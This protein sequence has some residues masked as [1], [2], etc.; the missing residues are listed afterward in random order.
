MPRRDITGGAVLA[1]ITG[2]IN[3]TDLS[4]SID[5]TS[6][7]PTG[8]NGKFYV[9]VD[10]GLAAEEK[11]L[12]T[13]RASGVLTVAS[14]GDRGVDGT[15]AQTHSSGA[16]IEHVGTAQDLEDANAH[17]FDTT[18]NDHTQYYKKG[19][20]EGNGLVANAGLIDVNVDN[21]TL[22]IASDV[23]KVKDLGVTTAKLADSSVTSAK[24]VDATIATGDLADNAVATAKIVDGAVTSAKILDATIATGDIADGAV[25]SAKIADG[26][27]A[28]AD[29][30]STVYSQFNA[31]ASAACNSALTISAV[32]A[33]AATPDTVAG[34]TLTFS[35]SRVGQ[36]FLVLGSADLT[37]TAGFSQGAGV[38]GLSVDNS[39]TIT[40]PQIIIQHSGGGSNYRVTLSQCWLYTAA[41]TSSHTFRLK[42]YKAA[43]D[44]TIVVQ[45]TH[46]VL[47]YV[48]FG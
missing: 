13:S 19:S 9:A 48:R 23:V 21:S 25:T 17:I 43:S 24:I 46:T 18:R 22:Q 36:V 8:T 41:D 44:D 4:I 15:A 26:T 10:R 38:V 35:P 40:N 14:T 34:T 33:P 2:T 11:I 5:A 6:G 32:G 47:T 28:P 45:T 7:W 30:A 31:T 39:N 42:A 12:V 27:I 1:H 37:Y 3:A 16:T 29:L 20:S